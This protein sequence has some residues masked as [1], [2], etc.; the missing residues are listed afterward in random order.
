M[1]QAREQQALYWE[2]CAATSLADVLQSQRRHLEARAVL[3][4]IC[5]RFFQG[6]SVSRLERARALLDQWA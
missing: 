5:D 2:L 6:F 3:A 4:P 1:R